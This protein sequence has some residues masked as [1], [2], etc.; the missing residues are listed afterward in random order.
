MKPSRLSHWLRVSTLLAL[1][2]FTAYACGGAKFTA[3]GGSGGDNASGGETGSGATGGLFEHKITCQGPEDCDDGDPCTVDQCGADGACARAPKCGGTEKCCDGACGQCCAAA[4]CDDGVT[5]T[6]DQCFAGG[7]SHSPNNAKCAVTEY[8]SAT[9]DCRRKEACVDDAGCDDGDFCTVDSCATALCDHTATECA[10]STLCC[11]GVGC[12]ECCEDSQCD[13]GDP[14]T[15][16]SCTGNKCEHPALCADGQSCCPKTDN[17][18]ATCGT[19]CSATD[20]NDMVG[21]TSDSCTQGT[22][23]HTAVDKECGAGN[24]CDP[25]NGCVKAAE[26]AKDSD[27]KPTA[28]QSAPSCVSGKC[29]FAGCGAGTKCCDDGCKGCCADTDCN[30]GIACTKDICNSGT[31]SNTADSTSCTVAAPICD[32][33]LGC[34]A[35]ASNADCNDNNSCTTDICD[36]STH[37][38]SSQKLCN[39]KCCCTDVDCQGGIGTDAAPPIGVNKCTYR[40]C[41]AGTCSSKTQVCPAGNQC[42]LYG[43]CGIET[44]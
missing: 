18:S 36:P 27:C 19:C 11:P 14:C 41:N 8:C 12:A 43:C 26:C 3:T 1:C 15:K 29:A 42:C 31:C 32:P 39:A 13:D 35:C 21:C 10:G 9:A 44:K 7:C 28:C 6:D 30:D 23:G 38:C 34:L 4:D 24:T 33:K 5:C 20:C 40:V 22:C 25:V 17:S 16:D 2:S 37:K